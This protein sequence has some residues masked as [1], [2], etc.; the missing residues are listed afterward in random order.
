MPFT[1]LFIH[2]GHEA[3]QDFVPFV[4]FVDVFASHA[5]S[6]SHVIPRTTMF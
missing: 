4:S 6:I 2:E 1:R 3:H 5:A